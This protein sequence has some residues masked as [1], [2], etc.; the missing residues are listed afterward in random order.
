MIGLIVA[1]GII[2]PFAAAVKRLAF[3]DTVADVQY[4][5]E[6]RVVQDVMEMC[7]ACAGTIHDEV[8]VQ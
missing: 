2:L 5:R 3:Y 7:V 1:V 8:Y 6:D 4:V